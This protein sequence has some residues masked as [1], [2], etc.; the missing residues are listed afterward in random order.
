[1]TILFLLDIRGLLGSGETDS[2]TVG[3][4]LVH[5]YSDT[6][7]FEVYGSGGGTGFGVFP[8]DI[9]SAG[10]IRIYTRYNSTNSTTID[11]TY[12]VEIYSLDWP[13]GVSIYD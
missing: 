8:Y 5:R 4:R 7:T 9:T 10:R 12:K 3:I 2:V 6:S 13:D 11:G 1:M